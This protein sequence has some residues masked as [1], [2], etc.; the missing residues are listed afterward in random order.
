[1]W[2]LIYFF[3]LFLPFVPAIMI[4]NRK[5]YS[6]AA[7]YFIYML[8]I[9]YIIFILYP[10]QVAR[11][12]IPVTGF[13][14][15]GIKINH[16]LDNPINCFPSF[17]V[18]AASAIAFII[19]PLSKRDGFILHVLSLLIALSV[20]YV[21]AHVFLDVVAGYLLAISFGIFYFKPKVSR[22][23]QLERDKRNILRSKYGLVWIGVI[24]VVLLGIMFLFY[25]ADQT[26]HFTPGY[27]SW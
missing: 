24:Y 22:I 25:L 7:M 20:L 6:Y 13:I 10:V 26:W 19:Q 18:A 5:Y 17:H 2:I 16:L 21:K 14:S 12:Q 9:G 8:L 15:W 23:I 11:V 27:P 4:K 1:E 3:T